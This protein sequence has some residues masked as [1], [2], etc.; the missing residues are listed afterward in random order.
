MRVGIPL[1]LQ[2]PLGLGL[3]PTLSHPYIENE[4]F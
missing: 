2:V 4:I 3:D 1:T